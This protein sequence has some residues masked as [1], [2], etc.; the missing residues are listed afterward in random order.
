MKAKLPDGTELEGTPDELRQFIP[1]QVNPWWTTPQVVPATPLV[2]PAHPWS[3]LLPS[4]PPI[5]WT[6]GGVQ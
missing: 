4:Y 3:P 2:P 6:S 1:F 5:V